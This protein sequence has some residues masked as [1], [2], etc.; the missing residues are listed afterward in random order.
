MVSLPPPLRA[1]RLQLALSLVALAFTARVEAQPVPET[2][3][4]VEV[5]PSIG[6]CLDEE[7]LRQGLREVLVRDGLAASHDETP[8]E[9]VVRVVAREAQVEATLGWIERATGLQRELTPITVPRAQCDDLRRS[10]VT[11]LRALLQTLH[12]DP[13]E[14]PR[15][16]TAH[17]APPPAPNP[18][19]TARP[20][21]SEP[22]R[23]PALGGMVL[24]A[25]VF[26][27][28]PSVMLGLGLG[29]RLGRD[30]WRAALSL[31]WNRSADEPFAQHNDV[32]LRVDRAVASLRGCYGDAS[33]GLCLV[34]DAGVLVARSAGAVIPQTAVAPS[35][36]LGAGGELV[37]AP[38]ARVALR[39]SFDVLVNVVGANFEVTRGPSPIAGAPPIVWEVPVV[40]FVLGI[41]PTL[42]FR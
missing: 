7:G 14:T 37:F 27:V 38:R 36:A 20:P 29:L 16:P 30:R 5:A 4:R 19:A 1:T 41:A 3:L 23:T 40:S 11:S 2:R 18:P 31:H 39:L 17:V 9:V 12:E 34:T 32:S 35:L 28:A 13:P 24:G 22:S 6:R 10:L 21:T 42:Q 15:E 33:L 25:A 26:N 8:Y